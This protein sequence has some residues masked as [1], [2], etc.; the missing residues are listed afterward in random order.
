MDAW[1]SPGSYKQ[2]LFNGTLC[3][4]MLIRSQHNNDAALL[5]SSSIPTWKCFHQVLELE[6]KIVNSLALWLLKSH[7]FPN[8]SA[9]LFSVISVTT[10]NLEIMEPKLYQWFTHP[11]TDK[12][13]L[14]TESHTS[15]QVW[16]ITKN[17]NNRPCNAHTWLK[18]SPGL[19]DRPA[20]VLLE[21]L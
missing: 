2:L 11:F 15:P 14:M 9:R 1:V 17:A 8:S 10:T 12:L 3:A 7:K 6:F 5:C 4:S 20:V 13:I 16:G 19:N 21:H 18:V